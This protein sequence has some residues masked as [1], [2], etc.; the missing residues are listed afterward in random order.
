MPA[1]WVCAS[2]CGDPSSRNVTRVEELLRSSE[3]LQDCL[4]GFGGGWNQLDPEGSQGIKLVF[5]PS[6][7]QIF[8]LKALQG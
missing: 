7:E 6:P 3:F 5:L 1:W 8:P 4:S 2:L